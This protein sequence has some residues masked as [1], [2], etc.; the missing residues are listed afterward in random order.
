MNLLENVPE[1]NAVYT[2]P[3]R[4]SKVYPEG[5]DEFMNNWSVALPPSATHG[6]LPSSQSRYMRNVQQA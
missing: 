2:Y 1:A 4:L 5:F 3:D 6:N